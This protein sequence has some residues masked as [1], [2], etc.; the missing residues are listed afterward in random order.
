MGNNDNYKIKMG[1]PA[2]GLEKVVLLENTD[3]DWIYYQKG[4]DTYKIDIN[5]NNK[6]KIAL[7]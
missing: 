1:N 6:A 4:N 2:D 5:G 3:A 7:R